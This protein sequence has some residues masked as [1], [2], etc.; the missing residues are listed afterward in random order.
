M[1][2]VDSKER[3]Q[4]VYLQERVAR[5]ESTLELGGEEEPGVMR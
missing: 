3:G 5:D 1:H 4:E 2:E